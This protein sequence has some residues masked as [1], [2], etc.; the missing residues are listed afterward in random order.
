MCVGWRMWF[1]RRQARRASGL[2]GLA[3]LIVL[4][5]IGWRVLGREG[6]GQGAGCGSGCGEHCGCSGGGCSGCGCCCSGSGCG[7]GWGFRGFAC[8]GGYVRDAGGMACDCLYVQP[9]RP[10]VCEGG[11]DSGASLGAVAGGVCANGRAPYLV[12]LGGS[13]SEREADG[14]KDR[15]KRDGMPRDTFIRRYGAK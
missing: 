3:V 14:L 12:G 6:C 9:C 13:M 4:A 5:L 10:G 7:G 2:R 11:F 1:C 15:A 8:A